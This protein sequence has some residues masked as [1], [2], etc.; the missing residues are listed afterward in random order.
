M[1][2]SIVEKGGAVERQ[3]CALGKLQIILMP[4][5]V[6]ATRTNLALA[7]VCLVD[8]GVK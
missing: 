4:A 8:L 1:E 5:I 2:Q 3:A 7:K 6:D